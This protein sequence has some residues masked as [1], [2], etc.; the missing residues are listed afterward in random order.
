MSCSYGGH[1]HD[2]TQ[3]MA[4]TSSTPA[5]AE[6]TNTELA[7]KEGMYVQKGQPLFT[8]YNPD[9]LWALL[10]LFPGQ[11]QAVKVG[12]YV[13]MYAESDPLPIHGKIDV[14]EPFYSKGSRS[15]AA[16]VY[17]DNSR[18]HIPVG[19]QLK[20][21]ISTHGVEGNWLPASAIVSLGNEKVVYVK[22]GNGF[23]AR[24]ITIGMTFNKKWQVISGITIK[25]SV[26]ENAA[27]MMDSE[28]FTRINK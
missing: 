7:L 4:Y 28:S 1:V 10:E 9:R 21:T 23:E 13:S 16:R 12:D 6:V 8:V 2:V 24:K 15:I 3:N 25:D 14:I 11:Q 5:P 20:A 19:S 26:A 17:F 27:F 22:N 18:L